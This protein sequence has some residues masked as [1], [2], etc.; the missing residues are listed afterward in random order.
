MSFLRSPGTC[1]NSES[2]LLLL[3]Q[4]LQF[5]FFYLEIPMK[6]SFLYRRVATAVHIGPPSLLSIVAQLQLAIRAWWW[7]GWISTPRLGGS[8]PVRPRSP[9]SSLSPVIQTV[10]PT[11]IFCRWLANQQQA[12]QL[13][14]WLELCKASPCRMGHLPHPP[15]YKVY[16]S[17][18][19]IIYCVLL[20]SSTL[21]PCHLA[22][23][24]QNHDR[25]MKASYS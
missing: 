2:Q 8:S 7:S 11:K 18:F 9:F 15:C 3:F 19:V 24:Y 14:Y 5:Q 10:Q 4:L 20:T 17:S 22:L 25:Y 16:S 1:T 21:S 6:A 12:R 23:G 13:A